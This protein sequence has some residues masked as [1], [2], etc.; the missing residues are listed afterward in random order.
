[1]IELVRKRSNGVKHTYTVYEPGDIVPPQIRLVR[2][3]DR[4]HAMKGDY[5]EDINGR[6]VPLLR[7]V[8]INKERNHHNM[9]FPGFCWQPFKQMIFSFPIDKAVLSDVPDGVNGKDIIF[10]KLLHEGIDP[11]V[12]V[13][14]VYPRFSRR[15]VVNYILKMFA[16]PQFVQH[17]FSDLG[18]MNKLKAA[19]QAQGLSVDAIA[20]KINEFISDPKANPGLRKWALETALN[21]LETQ[22][23]RSTL[24]ELQ[25]NDLDS[26]DALMAAKLDVKAL[27]AAQIISPDL[28]GLSSEA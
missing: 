14:R 10:A 3:K 21:S 7:R 17:L 11:E 24:V 5:V 1:M 27:P 13:K 26:L 28:P 4:H 23:K 19:L 18:Y 16:N 9:I 6:F 15:Q 12:A 8:C 2:Y 22:D 25:S 20:D